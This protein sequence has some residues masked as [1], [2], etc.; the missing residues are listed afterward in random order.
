MQKLFQR[1]DVKSFAG[2]N[3]QMQTVPK[4]SFMRNAAITLLSVLVACTA[5]G[6]Q[7]AAPAHGGG[8]PTSLNES[9]NLTVERIGRNDLIGITVYDSPELTRT[10][11]VDYGGEIRLPMLQQ[12][13]QAAGLYPE[14]LE[15]AIKTALIEGQ[16]L[17]D[18]V[19]TVSVVEYRSRPINVVGE[20]K[21]PVTFQATGVVTLLDALSQAGGLTEN[22]GAEILVSRQQLTPD[23]KS[24]SLIQRIPV[25]GLFD[26]VDPSQNLRLQGGEVI[27]VPEAGRVYVLGNVKSPGAIAIK[28][29]QSSVLKMLALS[30]GLNSFSAH[31]AYIYRAEGGSG[32]KN[33][34]PIELKK[35]MNRKSPDV[36]L[37]ANDI[38]YIP[39]A[40]GRKAAFSA[41]DRGLLMG[42]ALSSTLVYL[43]H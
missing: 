3:L 27:R 7:Q 9:S 16:V 17:V 18:P 15:N 25:R 6:Q 33:Q 26:T 34:I 41:L 29:G 22:A 43:Y 36:P 30:Q 35:I 42:V 5:S 14:D 2:Q 13:I 32:E 39:E 11:R 4:G 21:N 37:M 19:V 40:S 38:L 24:T 10:V 1:L 28:D 23:G 20:V 12:H 8:G 31:R